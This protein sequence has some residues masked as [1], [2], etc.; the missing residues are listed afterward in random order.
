MSLS[1]NLI[2]GIATGQLHG[3]WNN[4]FGISDRIKIGPD[5]ALS[6]DIIFAQ[7]VSTGCVFGLIVFY[8]A[9]DRYVFPSTPSGLGFVGGLQIGKT[10]A[11]VAFQ[12]SEDP[13]RK[14]FNLW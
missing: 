9:A 13:S 14:L 6:I 5:L 2:E 7:F 10:S 1:F 3:Y 11:Q 8:I 4:P 12:V